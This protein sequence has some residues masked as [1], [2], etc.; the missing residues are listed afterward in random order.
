MAVIRPFRGSLA[1]TFAAAFA[2]G[3]R[4]RGARY[5]SNGAVEIES[6]I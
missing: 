4:D 3:V 6:T 2:A 5:F 1:T